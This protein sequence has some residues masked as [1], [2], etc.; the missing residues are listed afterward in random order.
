MS[1]SMSISV[2]RGKPLTLA[3]LVKPVNDRADHSRVTE[4]Q[5]GEV[6]AINGAAY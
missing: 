2:C 4:S 3:L 5:A 1:A 6:R